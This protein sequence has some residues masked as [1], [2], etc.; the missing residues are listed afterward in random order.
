MK[1]WRKNTSP[2]NPDIYFSVLRSKLKSLRAQRR[3][4]KKNQRSERYHSI[5]STDEMWRYGCL[6]S[7][8]LENSPS[9]ERINRSVIGISCAPPCMPVQSNRKKQEKGK[10][11]VLQLDQTRGSASHVIMILVFLGADHVMALSN[12]PFHSSRNSDWDHEYWCWSLML[13]AWINNSP[14]PAWG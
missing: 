11:A 6:I 14:F 5:T 12:H 2:V 13:V 1:L 10:R 8:P 4:T 3:E 9:E 7:M